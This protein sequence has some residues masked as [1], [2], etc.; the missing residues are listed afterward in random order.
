MTSPAFSMTTVSLI[1][2]VF[3]TNLILVVEGGATDRAPTQ[4]DGFEF[5]HWREDAGA[6]DLDG[7]TAARGFPPVLQR[8]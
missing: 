1:S 4:K 6:A 5:S 2:D 7:D 3:A 8:T